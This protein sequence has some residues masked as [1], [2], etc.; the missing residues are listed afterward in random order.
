MDEIRAI[1]SRA[2][3]EEAA[4]GRGPSRPVRLATHLCAE[5]VRAQEI[6]PSVAAVAASAT[7]RRSGELQFRHRQTT[8]I[9]QQGSSRQTS[10]RPDRRR[11]LGYGR[12]LM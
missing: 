7:G 11:E 5:Y 6:D 8:S 12:T 3:I 9:R 4:L 2:G 1:A 10:S